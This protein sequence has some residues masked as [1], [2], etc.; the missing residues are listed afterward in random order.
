M[1]LVKLFKLGVML[2]T[3]LCIACSD[4]VS[5]SLEQEELQSPLSLK[6]IVEGDGNTRSEVSDDGIFTWSA[7]KTDQIAVYDANSAQFFT[8]TQTGFVDDNLEV[9]TFEAP[10][11]KAKIQQGSYAVYP[12]FLEPKYD[13]TT[14][15]V[16]LPTEYD[17]NQSSALLLATYDEESD[18]LNFT[19]IASLMRISM[20]NVPTSVTKF[21]F[22][23]E[24][25]QITGSFDVKEYENAKYI[26]T[27]SSD[28]N[29]QV[30]INLTSNDVKDGQ[31][32]FNI[33]LPV[34]TYQGFKLQLYADDEIVYSK[35][36][37]STSYYDLERRT[38][39]VMP[40]VTLIGTDA[41][42]SM[43]AAESIKVNNQMI[44][45]RMPYGADVTALRATFSAPK[46]VE[47]LLNGTAIEGVSAT[48][49]YSEP[50]MLQI[51][52]SSYTVVVAYSNLPIV[53]LSTP[54]HVGITTK[55]TYVEKSTFVLANTENGKNDLIVS[56]GMNI[57][58]RGNSTW[59][60][61]KKPY[62][63]KFDKKQSVLGLPKDKSWV[64][65][66]NW[67]DRTVMRNAVAFAI[68]KKTKSLKWT[69]NG[70][71]VDVVLNGKFIGNYYLCEKIKISS[72]R[73]NITEIDNTKQV[74][75]EG[76]E[77][78][79][80]YLV[81]LDSYYDEDYKFR[82][83]PQKMPVNF[84]SPD[85][86]V[87]QEQIDY[88]QG[89]FNNLESII[90]S[91]DFPTE[92]GNYADLIDVDSFIDWWFVQELTQNSEPNHPKSSYMHKDRLGK[93]IAGPVWDFDWGT[94][95]PNVTRFLDNT[96]IYYSALFRVH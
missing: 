32:T 78:T 68:A 23:A 1:N 67:M 62:A 79:G 12:A 81:E 66:A 95:K 15:T 83:E 50:V 38:L 29:N 13:G 73:V 6:A 25:S 59:G 85:E 86:A 34:G 24:G 51:G 22:E 58:G 96:A 18:E 5:S 61:P 93:L 8:W 19:H 14:L 70:E 27:Q 45:V 11:A 94:F 44:V 36:T 89:Y 4:E 80:G 84:K 39:I 75:T 20:E 64:L 28:E 57:K 9:A 91:D 69:P 10:N 71:F 65:L 35:S 63:V 49:D 55:T 77:L 87:P 82:T 42:I 54:D 47:I 43:S 37:S 40:T 56:E 30:T 48:T 33:P 76:D 52:E 90:Y 2:P 17:S 92:T 53:Y 88:L 16:T 31:L 74:I 3:M 72:D 60:Y 7:D 21:V 41:S 46:G 26:A